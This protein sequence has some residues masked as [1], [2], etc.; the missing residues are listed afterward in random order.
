V[1]STPQ[2]DL[3]NRTVSLP[4]GKVVG[5][6]TVLNGMVF[7]RGSKEDYDRWEELGN[8]GWNFADLLPY[9][10]K[11]EVF[12]P[13]SKE[14]VRIWGVGDVMEFHGERGHVHSSFP[15]FVWPSTRMGPHGFACFGKSTNGS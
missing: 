2:T 13:P 12:T 11:A 10:K 5:G 15:K 6:G 3:F 9:F 8:P 1:T 14:L 7:M 4:A